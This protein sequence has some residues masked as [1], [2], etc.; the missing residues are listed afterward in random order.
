MFLFQQNSFTAF[1]DIIPLQGVGNSQ[2][3]ALLFAVCRGK[4]SEEFIFAD[5]MARC[6]VLMGIPFKNKTDIDIKLKMEFN[7]QEFQKYLY[8]KGNI[9]NQNNSR[10]NINSS[11]SKT[12]PLIQP[13]TGN[14]WYSLQATRAVNQALGRVIC[15]KADY[16]ALI[17]LDSRFH[18]EGPN[19]GM[20]IIGQ[21]QKYQQFGQKKS[22]IPASRQGLSKWFAND[23]KEYHSVDDATESLIQFFQKAEIESGKIRAVIRK[24]MEEDKKQQDL[25]YNEDQ[26]QLISSKLKNQKKMQKQPEDSYQ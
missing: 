25:K 17:L 20:A 10:V 24:Q 13:L 1:G 3:G 14:E 22:Q 6:V 9:D 11:S 23:T 18:S 2:G 26:N 5:D 8:Q 19:S 4:V 12:V 21:S 7:D 16:G 15:H